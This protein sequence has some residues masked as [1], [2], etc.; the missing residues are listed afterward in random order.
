MPGRSQNESKKNWR[1][2]NPEYQ[3]NW[4]KKNKL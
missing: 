1:I 3:L 4:R 2:N